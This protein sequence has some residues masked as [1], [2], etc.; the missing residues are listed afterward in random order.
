MKPIRIKKSDLPAP[1]IVLEEDGSESEQSLMLGGERRKGVR[2]GQKDEWKYQ[3]A[4]RAN[5]R[6]R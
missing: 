4:Q 6:K 2:V 1:L 3:L 5:D